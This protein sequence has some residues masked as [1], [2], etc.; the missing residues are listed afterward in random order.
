ME[1]HFLIN[2]DSKIN[3]EQENQKLSIR[4]STKKNSRKIPTNT[5]EV[6]TDKDYKQKIDSFLEEG[7]V[8]YLPPSQNFS[9]AIELWKEARIL[10]KIV[11]CVFRE[12]QAWNNLATVWKSTQQI[13]LAINACENA[14]ELSGMMLTVGLTK[15]DILTTNE[16][17]ESKSSVLEPKEDSTNNLG[18][19]NK[20]YNNFILK[21]KGQ[22]Q[23][24]WKEVENL[25]DIPNVPLK[26]GKI[27]GTVKK[28][29]DNVMLDTLL[30]TGVVPKNFTKRRY[31]TDVNFSSEVL[32]KKESTKLKHGF[33]DNLLHQDIKDE[34]LKQTKDNQTK[35]LQALS[36]LGLNEKG[37]TSK[38][39]PIM[40]EAVSGRANSKAMKILGV[41]SMVTAGLPSQ[42]IENSIKIKNEINPS[43]EAD[44]PKSSR[45]FSFSE[46][47][48]PSDFSSEGDAKCF[49]RRSKSLNS[50]QSKEKVQLE[51]TEEKKT[52]T[53]KL[54]IKS[55]KTA[56]SCSKESSNSYFKNSESEINFKINSFYEGDELNF[57][58]TTFSAE[59]FTTPSIGS[60][61]DYNGQNFLSFVNTESFNE[62]EMMKDRGLKK[63]NTCVKK[64]GSSFMENNRFSRSRS[65]S[66]N[67]Q[68]VYFNSSM[69]FEEFRDSTSNAVELLNSFGSV[70]KKNNFNCENDSGSAIFDTDA[71]VYNDR[72][73][74]YKSL[75]GEVENGTEAKRKIN[76]SYL[77][78]EIENFETSLETE[79]VEEKKKKWEEGNEFFNN[80]N[81]I[82]P[83]SPIN[84]KLFSRTVIFDKLDMEGVENR[85][86]YFYNNQ[87]YCKKINVEKE[88]QQDKISQVTIGEYFR[89]YKEGKKDKSNKR[90]T[91]DIVKNNPKIYSEWFKTRKNIPGYKKISPPL[92]LFF[93]Q[94]ANTYGNWL[95]QDS[96][97]NYLSALKL[98]QLAKLGLLEFQNLIFKR[99]IESKY[100]KPN[101]LIAEING[102]LGISLLNYGLLK[103]SKDLMDLSLMGHSVADNPREIIRAQANVMAQGL[104]ET[105][106]N[107]FFLNFNQLEDE[108]RKREGLKFLQYFDYLAKI[109]ALQGDL[110]CENMS[111]FNVGTA[112]LLLNE[113]EAAAKVY[114]NLLG[115]DLTLLEKEFMESVYVP[116]KFDVLRELKRRVEINPFFKNKMDLL[117]FNFCEILIRFLSQGIK[118]VMLIVVSNLVNSSSE[119]EEIKKKILVFE[120]M[121][122]REM[123]IIKKEFLID[124]LN[125][126]VE[127]FFELKVIKNEVVKR[128]L[129]IG[130][131]DGKSEEMKEIFGFDVLEDEEILKYS[132]YSRIKNVI[133]DLEKEC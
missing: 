114:I 111:R 38:V 19:I 92:A 90:M 49:H 35:I 52:I 8:Q 122:N 94:L 117:T 7:W 30:S 22:A 15:D 131:R 106:R 127:K 25:P 37:S 67:S 47:Q 112:L 93:I 53:S 124:L 16:K 4:K 1:I 45:K 104:Y 44:I 39:A 86:C 87:V 95:C 11:G 101:T 75:S 31:S 70:K 42:N 78:R 110:E 55:V 17:N 91:K 129:E 79:V 21:K 3:E 105:I 100:Y 118:S 84:L 54:P 107:N 5:K 81:F 14:W 125:F 72:K 133:K 43:S 97:K 66:E 119:L 46:G 59:N 60:F 103:K 51:K 13:D 33:S 9:A 116:E 120:E 68:G 130:T 28:S 36:F 50:S 34:K 69:S 77:N 83:T 89:D 64:M 57:F 26:A 56:G 108:K 27:L 123:L 115:L 98:H 113:S 6:E 80:D 29:N 126:I 73:F 132:V 61:K 99:K 41:D 18:I 82:N 63:L 102:N 20:A 48:Q 23:K 32:P 85:N 74:S 24:E 62:S 12:A 2:Q 88:I 40:K 128:I 76:K 65:K 71:R 58:P 10:A 121:E 96:F 109:S